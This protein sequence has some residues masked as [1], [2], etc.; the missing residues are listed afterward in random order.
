V[1]F[2]DTTTYVYVF[3]ADKATTLLSHLAT[4]LAANE[5]TIEDTQSDRMATIECEGNTYELP[6]YAVSKRRYSG[7]EDAKGFRPVKDL[8]AVFTP[9][10]P[11]IKFNS[12]VWCKPDSLLD[13][14]QSDRHASK[15]KKV[16]HLTHFIIA[17]DMGAKYIRLKIAIWGDQYWGG[18]QK[19]PSFAK[20]I[21]PLKDLCEVWIMESDVGPDCIKPKM[22]ASARELFD[23]YYQEN[24]YFEK[25]S[26]DNYAKAIL[27]FKPA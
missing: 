1:G 11:A 14:D 17:L 10:S 9:K 20:L 24:D 25:A 15:G 18:V 13:E 6:I 22:K 7:D 5:Y 4:S 26:P 3:Q 23:E 16:L 27:E 2:E 19:D 12:G 8:K 21:K